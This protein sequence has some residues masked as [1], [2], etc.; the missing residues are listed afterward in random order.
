MSSINPVSRPQVFSVGVDAHV[1]L[2]GCSDGILVGDAVWR[3]DLTGLDRQRT[4]AFVEFLQDCRLMVCS[5]WT[6]DTD[7]TRREWPSVTSPYFLLAPNRSD[8]VLIS[9]DTPFCDA[10]VMKD[11]AFI[12]DHWPVFFF[13][14]PSKRWNFRQ[15][16]RHGTSRVPRR[17]ISTFE[18]V[19]RVDNLVFPPGN[20]T[21]KI[22]S[23]RLLPVNMLCS[24]WCF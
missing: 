10:G 17:W 11:I 3:A 16:A 20:L 4:C 19:A 8:F 22:A 1:I 24:S 2:A 15:R 21:T 9:A 6:D 23:W 12:S 13:C 7:T 18:F 5:S 14:A